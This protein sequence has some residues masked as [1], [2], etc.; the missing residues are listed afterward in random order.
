MLMNNCY[1]DY[2]VRNAT[3]LRDLI[4]RLIGTVIFLVLL[5]AEGQPTE[6]QS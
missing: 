3:Q 4:D 6:V 5:H 1:R 2:A